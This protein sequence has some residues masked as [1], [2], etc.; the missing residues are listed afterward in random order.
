MFYTGHNGT[1]LSTLSCYELTELIN[2]QPKD[3]CTIA[4]ETDKEILNLFEEMFG[5]E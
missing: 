4:L 5:E 2:Y 3:P 1:P